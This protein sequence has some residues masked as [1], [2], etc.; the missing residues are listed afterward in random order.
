MVVP[1]WGIGAEA[2]LF[3]GRVVGRFEG[4]GA[5]LFE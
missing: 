3:L 1:R 5:E 2:M 4:V